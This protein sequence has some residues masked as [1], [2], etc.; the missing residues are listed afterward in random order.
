MRRGVALIATLVVVVSSMAIHL[1]NRTLPPCCKAHGCAMMKRVA[2]GCAFSRCDQSETARDVNPVLA[3]LTMDSTSIVH[4][5]T[6]FRPFAACEAS[7]ILSDRIE[8][9]PQLTLV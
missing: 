4:S 7:L 2:S 3:V 1:P 9:P 5:T 8:H 6:L